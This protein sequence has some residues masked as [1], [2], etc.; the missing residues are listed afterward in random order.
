MV[1][2]LAAA[3]WTSQPGD[4]HPFASSMAGGDKGM[5]AEDSHPRLMSPSQAGVPILCW[6]S[7]SHAGVLIPG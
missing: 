2:S 4:C 1:L 6:C 7:P 5:D 3:Q